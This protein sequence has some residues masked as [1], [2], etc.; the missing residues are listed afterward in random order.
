[1]INNK[2]DLIKKLSKI[3][4]LLSNEENVDNLFRGKYEYN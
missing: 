1:M 3:G 2:S 4:N